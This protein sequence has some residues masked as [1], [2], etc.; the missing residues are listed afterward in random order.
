[1]QCA[2]QSRQSSTFVYQDKSHTHVWKLFNIHI[3]VS[4]FKGDAIIE[5]SDAVHR[6]VGTLGQLVFTKPRK[7][8]VDGTKTGATRH[9]IY[10]VHDSHT[11]LK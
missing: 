7:V 10:F 1:M 6:L 8:D 9:H 3:S 4:D 11:V 2:S 5:K